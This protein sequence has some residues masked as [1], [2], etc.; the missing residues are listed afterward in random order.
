MNQ[1]DD[2][3][4]ADPAPPKQARFKSS[5]WPGLIWVA[6]LAAVLIVLW[7]GFRSF[8]NSGPTVHVVFPITGGLKA[9]NT[10]VE[11]KGVKV[12]TVSA[13]KLDKSLRSIEVAINFTAVMAHHL[14]KTTQFW[15]GGKN[16]NI[17]NLSSIKSIIAGP[18]IGIDPAR[19][20]IKHRFKGRSRPP[21]LT[22]GESGAELTLDTTKI[23]NI[24]RGSPVYYKNYRV[25]RVVRRTMLPGG[26]RFH[27]EM[28]IDRTYVGLIDSRSRFWDAGAVHLKTGGSGP[29]LQIQSVPALF[30]GAIAFETPDSKRGAQPFHDNETFRLYASEQSAR[31]AP[32]V[33]AVPYSVIFAGGP[34]GLLKGAPVRL[35]G[36]PAGVV[37][38][39][40][41]KYHCQ[42][43]VL[44][45]RVV[46]AI[47]PRDIPLAGGHWNFANP[48]PQMNALFRRLIA[49]GLRA[50]LGSSTPVVGGKLISLTLLKH[51]P[52]ATLGAGDPPSIPAMPTGQS[53]NQIMAQVSG[54]LVKINGVTSQISALSH[55]PRTRR[56]LDRL[57]RTVAHI[58]AITRTT[59]AQLPQILVELRKSTKDA[60]AAL[61]S[62]H[63]LLARQGSVANGPNAGSLPRAIDELT[64]AAQSLRE[65]TDYLQGHPN[66]VLFGKRK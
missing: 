14:G 52:S 38:A 60:Q 32:S 12:G 25:G 5:R 45:T 64:R 21:V 36:A 53:I 30:N 63:R 6:P 31:D 16:V 56:T 8:E 42:S 35:E 28:F 4:R 27:I 37:T 29:S 22:R 59:S 65:L 19:G 50:Q 2:N 39:V 51:Q 24:S 7:L 55:S 46:I 3:G 44:R 54:I 23:G 34:H 9:G 17:S 20:P 15:I 40:Q 26:H 18:Y 48:R 33:N 10:K 13:V 41:M 66:A 62:A 47:E 49:N 1:S 43:G 58:G 61:R 57:D 11:Y